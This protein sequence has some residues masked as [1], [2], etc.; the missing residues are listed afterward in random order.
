MPA[1]TLRQVRVSLFRTFVRREEPR[2]SVRRVR[3]TGA[4]GASW[5]FVVELDSGELWRPLSSLQTEA[6]QPDELQKYAD[7]VNEF[8]QGSRADKAKA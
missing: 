3:I 8:L 7:L 1:A 6:Y 4:M 5:E 2:A